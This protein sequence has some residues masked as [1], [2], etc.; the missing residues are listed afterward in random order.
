MF[1][2]KTVAHKNSW[3][4]IL[5]NIAELLIKLKKARITHDDFHH[6]NMIFVNNIPILIDL[7]HMRIHLY[8]SIWFRHNYRKD[9]K[10]FFRVLGEI[11]PGA[12]R[13]AENIFL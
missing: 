4:I 10:N 1:F 12:Q 5:E 9:V 7:D 13:M 3:K 2:G 8:N 6:N 11:N